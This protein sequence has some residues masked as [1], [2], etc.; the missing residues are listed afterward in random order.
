MSK[1]SVSQIS[2]DLLDSLDP[3]DDIS[4][5]HAKPRRYNLY[6]KQVLEHSYIRIELDSEDLIP[7]YI[8]AIKKEKNMDKINKDTGYLRFSY[9][10]NVLQ[11]RFIPKFK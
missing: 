3:A 9:V 10:G 8:Q 11:V 7:R 4:I 6:W 1:S 2:V 5:H